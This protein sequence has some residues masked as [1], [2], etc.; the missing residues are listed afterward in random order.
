MWDMRLRLREL[1]ARQK[2][3]IKSAYELAKRS[4]GAINT[5]TAQRLLSEKRPPKG[6]EFATL[7]AICATLNC[8]P[9]QLLEAD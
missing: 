3:P 9:S 6:V 8:K 5:T 2:P 7:D 4:G 1:M